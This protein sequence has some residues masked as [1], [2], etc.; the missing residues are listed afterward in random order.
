MKTAL[1]TGG[2]SGIGL[3]VAQRL[4]EDFEVAIVDLRKHPEFLSFDVDVRDAARAKEIVESLPNLEALVTCAGTR[5]EAWDEV[6]SVD[7]GGT[8]NYVGA[9]GPLFRRKKSGKI[10]TI[11]ATCAMRA[12][13]NLASHVAA[14]AAILGL[15]RA[16]AR[17]LGRFNVNVNSIAPGPVDLAA[18]I[19]ETALGRLATAEDV[20]NAVAFLCSERARAITGEVIR[21]DG[22]QLA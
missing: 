17:D 1:V 12:R 19:E 7:L 16:V 4:S 10:V 5:D 8:W 3:A 11:S 13:R 2:A 20:A 14:K 15:T 22:G 21:V 9:V 18:S 6:M